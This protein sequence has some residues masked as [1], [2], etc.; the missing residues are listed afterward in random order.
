MTGDE[1]ALGALERALGHR[2]ARPELLDEALT[3]RSAAAQGRAPFGF[4]RLEFLGDRVL[5]LVVADLLLLRFPG[6]DEGALSRRH[7]ALVCEAALAR[8]ARSLDLGALV[9]GPRAEERAAPGL[10][11]DACEAVIGALYADGGLEAAERFIAAAWAPL[12]AESETPPR[13]AKTTLQEW[14]QGRG[15]AL[16]S[17]RVVE[18]LGPEHAPRFTVEVA[19]EGGPPARARG[20]S[21]RA[22]EQAAAAALIHRLEGGDD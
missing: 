1:E 19:V 2:F 11:A 17:Y 15:L 20:P 18:V 4:D 22:A 5:S 14:A 10:L 13:D 8:V 7:A 9:R 16:P 21:K 12:V 3:H 6:E